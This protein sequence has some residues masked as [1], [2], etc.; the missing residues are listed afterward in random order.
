MAAMSALTREVDEMWRSSLA[1][2]RVVK[3]P[4]RVPFRG[5]THRQ[6]V[7]FQGSVGWGEFAPFPEYSP[8]ESSWWLDSAMEAA[9]FGWPAPVRA[10]V[11]VN[12]IVP[13]CGATQAADLARDAAAAGYRTIKVKVAGVDSSLAEDVARVTAVREVFPGRIR[14]DANAAWTVTEA[15]DA[16]AALQVAA[17]TLEYVE[18]PC[19]TLAEL[20]QVRALSTV[21]VAADESIRRSDDPI[22]AAQAAA[23]DVL[24]VKAAPLG[25]VSRA[26]Q[27]VQASGLPVVVSSA[28]DTAVG[29]AAGI[30]LAA[31]VP[32]LAGDCGLGTGELFGTDVGVSPAIPVDGAFD[33]HR[34][35]AVSVAAIEAAQAQVSAEMRKWWLQRMAHA[36]NAGS[37][38]RVVHMLADSR[39]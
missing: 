30:A 18:Q 8:A 19:A 7:L 16:L 11:G 26:L 33:A 31:A 3:L 29:L 22:R 9:W 14:V 25:G 4:L 34:P 1:S 39:A 32:Q 6:A 35:I 12:A 5:V 27:V 38:D 10:S 17:G 37:R 2:A 20:A 13:G 36:W 24:V 28:L 23:A 15:V 21:P